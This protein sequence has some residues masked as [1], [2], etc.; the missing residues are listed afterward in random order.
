[1][2]LNRC[3]PKDDRASEAR[4]QKICPMQCDKRTPGDG[5]RKETGHSARQKADVDKIGYSEAHD[6]LNILD[7]RLIVVSFGFKRLRR[8]ESKKTSKSRESSILI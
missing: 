7:G 2:S 1:M 8:V 5:L 4:D 6:G 3:Q